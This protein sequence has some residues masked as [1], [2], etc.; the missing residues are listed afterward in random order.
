LSGDP[1]EE[2]G[3]PSRVLFKGVYLVGDMDTNGLPVGEIGPCYFEQKKL[4]DAVH[5]EQGIGIF[6][7]SFSAVQKKDGEVFSY[8]VWGQCVDSLLPVTD[9]VAFIQHG[10]EPPVALGEWAR[11]MEIVGELMEST[12]DYPLRYRVREFPNGVVLEAIG[13]GEM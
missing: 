2:H 12:E 9:K 10:R 11:V 6:V 13:A 1:R 8:C 5:Q 3:L 4:L 7:A